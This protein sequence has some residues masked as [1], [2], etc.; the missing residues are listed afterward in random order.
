MNK[1]N[2]ILIG[3]FILV[4]VLSLTIQASSASKTHT[5][6]VKLNMWD[7]ENIY[8]TNSHRWLSVWKND[9]IGGYPINKIYSK[10]YIKSNK[11]FKFGNTY[12]YTP[13]LKKTQYGGALIVKSE[14]YKF[15]IKKRDSMKTVKTYTKT[16]KPGQK[17]F[18][19]LPKNTWVSYI[20]VTGK[21][22]YG[23]NKW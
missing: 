16:L 21:Y 8:S 23:K 12:Y 7:N 5:Q 2:K 6:T 18:L 14:K 11:P 3:L 9:D 15:T 17:L 22:K 19:K 13:K 20:K 4:V 1:K 10:T